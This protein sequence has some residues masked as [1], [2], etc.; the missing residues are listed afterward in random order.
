MKTDFTQNEIFTDNL[1]GSVHYPFVYN[2]GF[3]FP[4]INL[5][6]Q[7][8]T[9]TLQLLI[10]GCLFQWNIK[11]F[12]FFG[13]HLVF[14]TYGNHLSLGLSLS[15]QAL[16]PHMPPKLKH[17]NHMQSAP[18]CSHVWFQSIIFR[19]QQGWDRWSQISSLEMYRNSF[20]T[21]FQNHNILK[22]L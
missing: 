18:D 15:A 7:K 14:L 20:L 6:Y 13:G 22:L 2:W 8:S 21:A 5:L 11:L 17:I 1:K 9:T 3:T 16:K 10:N 4:Q 19:W 12:P